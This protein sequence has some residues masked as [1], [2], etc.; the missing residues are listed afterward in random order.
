MMNEKWEEQF[1]EQIHEF[2]GTIEKF[3]KGEIDR[4]AYKGISGGFGSYAQRDPSKHMLR[5][6]MAGGNLTEKRSKGLRRGAHEAHHL[7]D[8]AAP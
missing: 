4:K 5:L 8:C 3:D 7:R 2:V 1:R 6:R